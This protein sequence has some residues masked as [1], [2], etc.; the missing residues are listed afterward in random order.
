MSKEHIDSS[1]SDFLKEEGVFEEAQ[2]QAIKRLP[3]G[4]SLRLEGK[5]DSEEPMAKA[6]ENQPHAS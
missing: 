4:S 5:E 6:A 2:N 1:I 3:P